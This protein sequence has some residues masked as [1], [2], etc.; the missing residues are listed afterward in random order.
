MYRCTRGDV[1][2]ILLLLWFIPPFS[3]STTHTHTASHCSP[4]IKQECGWW[5]S[6]FF[7]WAEDGCCV[8][9]SQFVLC[10]VVVILIK[11]KGLHTQK[12][13]KW[14]LYIVAWHHIKCT[15]LCWEWVESPSSSSTGTDITIFVFFLLSLVTL[16][17][18][19]YHAIVIIYYTAY[20]GI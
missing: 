14:S 17:P 7:I 11:L 16:P 12:N 18:H 5:K 19:H 6:S 13:Q 3:W 10:V 1:N 20:I 8:F 4:S 9:V 2:Q 15:E